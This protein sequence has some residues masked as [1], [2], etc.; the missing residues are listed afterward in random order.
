VLTVSFPMSHSLH[1]EAL[2]GKENK[3][4]IEKTISG[5]LNTSLRVNFAL[6]GDIEQ[7]DSHKSDAFIRSALDAF[8]GR[9]IKEE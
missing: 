7:K 8:N 1:K 9:V 5:I 2:E 6:S 4:I 3:A